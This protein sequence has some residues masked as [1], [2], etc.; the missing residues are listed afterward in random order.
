MAR[1]T[2]SQLFWLAPVSTKWIRV[3]DLFLLHTSG[4]VLSTEY[5][6]ILKLN[7]GAESSEGPAAIRAVR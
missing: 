6:R 2:I 3:V 7:G 5:I 1:P 4:S